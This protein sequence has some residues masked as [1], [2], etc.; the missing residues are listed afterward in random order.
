VE[1]FQSGILKTEKTAIYKAKCVRPF[2]R[3]GDTEPNHHYRP[4]L[5]RV[6]GKQAVAWEWELH[7]NSVNDLVIWF[8]FDEHAILFELTWP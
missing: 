6:V 2:M 7:P 8:L 4:W 1:N 3:P 5:E